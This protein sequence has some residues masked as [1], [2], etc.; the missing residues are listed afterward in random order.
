VHRL[1]SR[2]VV[3]A[4]VAAISVGAVVLGPTSSGAATKGTYIIGYEASLSGPE[5]S[6]QALGYKGA[7]ARVALQNSQGGVNGHKLVLLGADDQ[8]SPTVAPTAAQSLISRGAKVIASGGYYADTFESYA[9]AANVL[10]TGTPIGLTWGEVPNYNMFS[11]FGS[12]NP[13][14][15]GYTSFALIT[16]KTGG[17]NV[18][19]FANNLVNAIAGCKANGVAASSIGIKQGLTD[20]SI[21]P[22]ATDFSSYALEAKNSGVNSVYLPLGISQ[23]IP[24][25]VAISQ[26]GFKPKSEILETGY[27]QSVLNSPTVLQAGQG[28]YFT[29]YFTPVE[30][31]TP[32]TKLFQSSLKKYVG[33]SGVPSYDEYTG[34]SAADE[35]ITALKAGGSNP[36]GPSMQKGMEKITSYTAGGLLPSKV[37]FA[38]SKFGTYPSL[39]YGPNACDYV[40]QLKGSSF[41]PVLG[42]KP[43]C[44]KTVS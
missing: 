33:L 26:S 20:T 41:V 43:V 34:W 39:T 14:L 38:K 1:N 25:M 17:T 42:G 44:G 24:L 3:C 23:V 29:S 15:P 31:N 8:S 11:D 2:R 35:A 32:A 22:T 19:C 28:A 36:T 13:A 9:R 6:S 4:L 18:A 10:V 37:S 7:Q 16:K 40:L 5:A 12:P 21:A 30:L 27:G